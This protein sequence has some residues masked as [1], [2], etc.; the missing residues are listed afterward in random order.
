M[1][2]GLRLDDGV[3][4]MLKSAANLLTKGNESRLYYSS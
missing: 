1:E 4:F 2:G 3:I